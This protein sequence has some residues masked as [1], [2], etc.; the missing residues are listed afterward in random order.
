MRQ[1]HAIW[2]LVTIGVSSL[3]EVGNMIIDG[4]KVKFRSAPGP[5]GIRSVL[6][7]SDIVSSL[8]GNETDKVPSV[9]AVSGA[10]AA[11]T[12]TVNPNSVAY[13][14]IVA[15]QIE[16]RPLLVTRPVIDN[17]STSLTAALSA[18]TPVYNATNV[19]NG[20]ADLQ[21]GDFI[22]LPAHTGGVRVFLHNGGTAGTIADFTLV[23]QPTFDSA[24][25]RALFTAVNGLTYN[26]TTGQFRL[27]GA[28]TLATSIIASLSNTFTV[29]E[30][31]GSILVGG[32]NGAILNCAGGAIG[33]WRANSSGITGTISN[34]N[35]IFDDSRTTPKGFEYNGDYSAGYTNRSLVD[36]AYVDGR[37]SGAISTFSTTLNTTA[38]TW[39]DVTHNFNFASGE[40]DKFTITAFDSTSEGVG[41]RFR[42][43][44]ANVMQVMTAENVTGLRV[45]L[46]KIA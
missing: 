25:I 40:F 26:N 39:T 35:A 31:G 28:L 2:L 41:L 15:G 38:G 1:L 9:S 23:E 37:V 4:T 30:T 27:G 20:T 24:T 8:G 29:S 13:L 11:S 7:D 32:G 14:R 16:V 17:T 6:D 33:S 45:R 22:I 19:G 34:G 21:E 43:S 5:A 46:V 44:T 36:K 42:A 10:L 18:R 12:L 3:L